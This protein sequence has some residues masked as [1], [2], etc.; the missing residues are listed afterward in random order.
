[1]VFL[2]MFDF[3]LDNIKDKHYWHPIAVVQVVDTF[4]QDLLYLNKLKC[5]SSTESIYFPLCYEIPCI[6]QVQQVPT[7]EVTHGSG[8]KRVLHARPWHNEAISF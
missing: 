4:V 1:M 5:T 6:R 2:A 3:Q 7:L 8:P